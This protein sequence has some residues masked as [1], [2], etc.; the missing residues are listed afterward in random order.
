MDELIAQLRAVLVEEERSA[1]AAIEK[2]HNSRRMVE[3]RMVEVPIRPSRWRE[4][5]WPPERVLRQVAAHRKMLDDCMTS[6]RAHLD[7]V[8][9][10]EE[11]RWH[12]TGQGY[13]P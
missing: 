2:S 12:R 7:D 11:E 5:A 6:Y 9:E 3:G 10:D 13:E 1:Q 4:S 8:P